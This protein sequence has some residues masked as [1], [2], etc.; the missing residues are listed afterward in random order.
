MKEQWFRNFERSLTE[1][2]DRHPQKIAY[3]L[4]AKDAD[5]LT[6]DQLADAIDMARL[7]AKEG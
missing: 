7:R 4:A 1:R 3:A 2:E 6:A 5:D